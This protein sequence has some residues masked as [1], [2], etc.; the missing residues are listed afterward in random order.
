MVPMAGRYLA[1][2]IGHKWPS[3]TPTRPLL[4]GNWR[5]LRLATLVGLRW[6]AIAGQTIGVL[7]VEFGLGFPLPLVECLALIA[8]L[9]RCS[10]SGCCFSG[11]ATGRPSL[12]HQHHPA[13]L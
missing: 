13:R 5:P 7:F 10:T 6:L 1:E 3:T 12:A 4:P 11:S 9:G 2:R 8:A